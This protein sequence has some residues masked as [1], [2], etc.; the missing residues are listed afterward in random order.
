MGAQVSLQRRNKHRWAA[1]SYAKE[2][3]SGALGS[4]PEVHRLHVAKRDAKMH[5]QEKVF[6]SGN[7]SL[8]IR[9]ML[10]A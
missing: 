9:K 1:G 7:I 10:T 6:C 3:G 5:L 4:A 2:P 8:G